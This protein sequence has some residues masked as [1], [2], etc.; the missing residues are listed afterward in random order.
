MGEQPL[1]EIAIAVSTSD[2]IPSDRLE[3][4][5]GL[6]TVE[7]DDLIFKINGQRLFL[8]SIVYGPPG[9]LLAHVPKTT[10]QEDVRSVRDAGLDMM[11]I[12][13]HIARPE[14]YAA[15]DKLGVLIWQDLPLV[16]GYSTKVKESARSMARSTV[17]LLAH[18]PSV[19]VWS[20]HC[21]PN[22]QLVPEPAPESKLDV[23]I[24]RRL[25]TGRYFLPTWNLSVLDTVVGRELRSADP[26]RPVVPRSGGLP[27]PADQFS[28]DTHL[29]LG[30]HFGRPEQL[31]EIIRYWPRLASFVGGIGTQS[32][33]IQDWPIEAPKWLTA[34]QGAFGRYLPRSAYPD[35][36]AWAAATRS[37][38][39]DVLRT[40]IETLR[41]LKYRPAGGL[42]VT[43]LADAEPAGGFGVLDFDRHRKPAFDALVDACRPVVVIADAPPQIATPGT[44]LSLAV[45]AINDRQITLDEAR[46]TA[47]ARLNDWHHRVSWA[48]TLPADCCEKVGQL[49]F[50]VPGEH[51]PLT[52]D[53]ELESADLTVSN[54]YQTVVIPTAE[55]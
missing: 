32:A 47:T 48:G 46:I 2:Y 31:A 10:L 38:Q 28:S 8:K 9:P 4:R 44:H 41:R 17:D 12:Y 24:M 42:C 6:R 52:I 27:A 20:G 19:V 33:A 25:K 36:R 43:A 50:Q 21:E 51:G 18:H 35:G 34:E 5:V 55:G 3:R 30:W 39:A 1:Y 15:A 26:S 23:S 13:G 22:G 29:W 54:R 16:G 37:Y 49:D 7:M 45:H 14:T 11:R 40:Q 53:L